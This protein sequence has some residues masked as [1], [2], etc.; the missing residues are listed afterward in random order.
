MKKEL[1]TG[2][3]Y[4]FLLF[5]VS[6]AND[7]NGFMS[8][9]SSRWGTPQ[10]VTIP[11]TAQLIVYGLVA[12]VLLIFGIKMLINMI[13]LFVKKKTSCVQ[14]I[15]FIK[16]RTR[17]LKAEDPQLCAENIKALEEYIKKDDPPHKLAA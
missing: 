15:A 3:F 2:F 16:P 8:D 13:M 11:L 7:V 10:T 17:T 4:V 14:T 12:L 1:F 6:A 5:T 9:M